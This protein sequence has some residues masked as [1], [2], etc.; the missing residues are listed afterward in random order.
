MLSA[1][2]ILRTAARSVA[3][4]SRSL[5]VVCIKFFFH[6]ELRKEI[7]IYCLINPIYRLDV[8]EEW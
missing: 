5:R 1:R 8:K 6:Y 7:W 2:P 4:A 3:T